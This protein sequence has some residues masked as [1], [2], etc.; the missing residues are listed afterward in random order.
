VHF[1]EQ[2][3][4]RPGQASSRRSASQAASARADSASAWSTSAK[5]LGARWVRLCGDRCPLSGR[6]G[7]DVAGDELSGM[8]APP[9]QQLCATFER[10]RPVLRQVGLA[11]GAV[12]VADQ[13][14]K[15]LA[16]LSR[17]PRGWLQPVHNP[18][19]LL[20]MYSGTRALLVALALATLIGFSVH[21]VHLVRGGILPAWAA[22]LLAGGAASNLADRVVQGAVRDWLA[23]PG[24]VTN[25]ADL[26]VAVGAVCYLAAGARWA[27]AAWAAER[28]AP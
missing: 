9:Q 23:L 25:L 5:S 14:T 8:G 24:V 3:A 4:R 17:G 18:D 6:E 27:V 11:V 26:A 2:E 7:G 21:L 28:S 10:P 19:V 15:T 13:A 20:S 1:I 16:H 12:L 22:G